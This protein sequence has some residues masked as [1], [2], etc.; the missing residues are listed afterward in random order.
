MTAR[1]LDGKQLAENIR[2]ELQAEI[3]TFVRQTGKRPGLA[4]VL[5]R[6]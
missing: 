4:A 5:G 3:E 1:I 2:R 6:G